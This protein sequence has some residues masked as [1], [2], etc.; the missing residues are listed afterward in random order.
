MDQELC[1]VADTE[2]EEKVEDKDQGKKKSF[3]L[4]GIVDWFTDLFSSDEKEEEESID[5]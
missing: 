4:E 3:F 5:D 1:F 2:S